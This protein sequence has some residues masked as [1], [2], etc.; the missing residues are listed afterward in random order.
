M[1]QQ[2]LKSL[3]FDSSVL[4]DLLTSPE[5]CFL[6]YF[7]KYIKLL[8]KEWHLFKALH[9]ETY[10][11]SRNKSTSKF[12][13]IRASDLASNSQLPN[14]RTKKMI[15]ISN[16][17]NVIVD[18]VAKSEDHYSI[19]SSHSVENLKCSFKRNIVEDSE[20]TDKVHN[21]QN[22]SINISQDHNTI[23]QS[24]DNYLESK[25]KQKLPTETLNFVSD[26]L[27][28]NCNYE[29]ASTYIPHQDSIQMQPEQLTS[30]KGFFTNSQDDNVSPLS[31]IELKQTDDKEINVATTNSCVKGIGLASIQ[32]YSN[33]S[34]NSEE[35]DEDFDNI[36]KKKHSAH[37][38]SSS[39][40]NDVPQTKEQ[41]YNSKC[42]ENEKSQTQRETFWTPKR[43][44]EQFGNTFI[45][46]HSHISNVTS[47]NSTL[48]HAIYC[49]N[50]LLQLLK[51]LSKS[52]VLPYN[53]QP[54]INALEV[55]MALYET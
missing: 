45:N 35:E 41:F 7:L 49:L 10:I 30:L 47:S 46:S 18:C 5:T 21:S 53:P 2:F 11:D 15:Q 9:Q 44:Q 19:P 4:L 3:V 42:R 29:K 14:S 26:S 54:L 8:S 52:S 32:A 40:F 25:M 36:I 43:S 24:K 6:L 13:N 51:R 50:R 39:V 16:E 37:D 22:V 28:I 27:M 1:F 12:Y 17:K 33:N 34:S 48:D 20:T 38:L 55:C 23:K 31:K